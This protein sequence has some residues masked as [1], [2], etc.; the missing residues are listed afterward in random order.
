[1]IKNAKVYKI[2]LI[3]T[4]L[5]NILAIIM[6]ITLQNVENFLSF[7]G[8]L[9]YMI[10]IVG[11]IGCGSLRIIGAII[12]NM[13]S[14]KE[15]TGISLVIFSLPFLICKWILKIWIKF[16]CLVCAIVF[17]VILPCI[18]API[19]FYKYKDELIEG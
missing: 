10:S 2:C 15:K 12:K 3:V 7:L 4:V 6:A 16:V 17:P 14:K 1:M 8:I 18:S 9:F 13:F 11:G 19:A 5:T